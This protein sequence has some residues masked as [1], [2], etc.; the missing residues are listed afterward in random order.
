LTPKIDAKSPTPHGDGEARLAPSG[1]APLHREE[2]NLTDEVSFDGPPT[3][4]TSEAISTTSPS[5]GR[6]VSNTFSYHTSDNESASSKPS[7]GQ[8]VFRCEDEP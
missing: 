8:K 2:S 5:G 4:S 7:T 3:V 1:P 6:F